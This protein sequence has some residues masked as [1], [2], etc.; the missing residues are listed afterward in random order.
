ML[1]PDPRLIVDGTA[2]GPTALFLDYIRESPVRRMIG[3]LTDNFT[4]LGRGKLRLRLELMLHEMAG[5]KIAGEYQFAGNEITLDARL[6]PIQRAGGRI[7]FTES[8]FTVGDVR[9]QL[10]GGD[11]RISGGSRP[12]CGRGRR[13]RRPCDR[14]RPA[15]AVR[16]SLAPAAG[17]RDALHRVGDGEGG[18]LAADAGLD[19]GRP[20]HHVPRAAVEGRGRSAGRCAWKYFPGEGRDRISVALGPTTGR[21]VVVDFLRALQTGGA[22][23]TAAGGGMQLQRTPGD[24]QPRSPVRRRAFPSAAA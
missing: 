19:A 18:A 1:D 5:S 4:S 23:G 22:A 17:G 21:I 13:C 3:G 14:G 6:P 20:V 12:R 10:F 16:P 7:G 15:P 9:G 8:S 11:V 2:E 24:A